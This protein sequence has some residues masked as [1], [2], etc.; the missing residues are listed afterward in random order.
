MIMK[1]FKCS[2]VF[3]TILFF[4]STPVTNAVNPND[5]NETN[6]SGIDETDIGRSDFSGRFEKQRRTPKLVDLSLIHI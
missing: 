5:D 6:E 2:L 3:L 4:L 1:V